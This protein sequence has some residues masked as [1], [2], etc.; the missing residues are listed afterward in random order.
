MKNT[1]LLIAL[2]LSII[3]I[4]CDKADPNK[5]D[6]EIRLKSGSGLNNG[7]SIYY[8]VLSENE[9]YMEHQDVFGYDKTNADW[10]VDGGIIPFTTDYKKFVEPVGEY[11]YLLV[12]A[13]IAV[14]GRMTVKSGKQTYV[15]SAEAIYP[16]GPSTLNIDIEQP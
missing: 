11:Y 15:I 4:G 3:F 13:G 12:T 9:N 2:F 14:S 6:T 5:S 16:G 8:L 10:Y 7:A 1:V